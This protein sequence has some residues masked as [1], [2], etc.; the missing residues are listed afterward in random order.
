MIHDL[1]F[2]FIF[3]FPRTLLRIHY[4]KNIQFNISPFHKLTSK[5]GHYLFFQQS[6]SEFAD[7]VKHGKRRSLAWHVECKGKSMYEKIS[8][9]SIKSQSQ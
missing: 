1:S 3:A 6:S 4:I 7:P 9:K 5:Y 8:N 2:P